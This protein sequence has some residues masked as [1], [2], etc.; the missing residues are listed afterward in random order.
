MNKKHLL[1][2]TVLFFIS[3]FAE[4]FL[5]NYKHWY[6]LNN[7]EVIPD[8]IVM[9]DAYTLN[10]DGTYS[11]G[12]GDYSITINGL[13]LDLKSACFDLKIPGDESGLPTVTSLYQYF[14]DDGHQY[15]YSMPVKELWSSQPKSAYYI[16]H[17]YGSCHSA[18]FVPNITDNPVIS[19]NIR[20]NPVIPL[21]FSLLRMAVLFAALCFLYLF[22][23]SSR[24]YDIPY[25][26]VSALLRTAVLLLLFL[27]HTLIFWKLSDLNPSFTWNIPEHH[28]QYQELAEALQE[29]SAA[30]L[31]QP[32]ETL[33]TLANPY[34]T[35][36][37]SDVLAGKGETFPY[38]TAYYEGKYYVYFGIVPVLLYYLPYHALTGG[39]LSNHTAVFLSL[40]LLLLGVLSSLHQLIKK[41]FP[42]L[43]LGV[44]FLTTELF[45]LGSNVLYMA[46]RPDLYTVPI[47]TGLALGM[48]GLWCF[49]R[50]DEPSRISVRYLSAGALLTAL[51]AGCRPQLMVF[52]VFPVILFKKYLFSKGF[53]KKKEGRIAVAA[54]LIPV[55]AVAAFL[56]Y[57]NYVRFGSPF[58]LGSSYNLTTNDMRYRGW[59]WGRIPLGL[60]VYLIQPMK[61]VTS[62][63]FAEAIFTITQYMGISIQEYT[64]GGIFAT[65]L[66][67]WLSAAPF[68]LRKRCDKVLR[69]PCIMAIASFISALAVLVADTELS[70]ILWRYYNDFSLFIMLTA[71][72]AAWLLSCHQ[73]MTD[74]SVRKWLVT[75]LVVCF[76]LEILFQGSTFFVDTSNALMKDRPD[77]YSQMKYLFAFWL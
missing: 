20:L 27:F 70:G 60:F 51:I 12:Y 32:A 10:E 75:F 74:P 15:E 7:R 48:L 55:C 29:G 6:T 46:K 25:L 52:A 16:Y 41:W 40:T 22:R 1:H 3:L 4:I 49:L 63:P 19:L 67:S 56:M 42:S 2:Y 13:D 17:L 9:G 61:L 64:I 11:T 62:F 66:F 5:F 38:D 8:Q 71:L 65:H 47:V 23:P 31:K 69:I 21:S 24:V 68:L 26:T 58:D 72:L 50:A 76:V 44:W 35:A 36:Y 77:L 53:Y 37:A 33:K 14:T 39:A 18:R 45:L 54:V 43:S 28:K 34:D 59:V 30:L 73:K 57:Y